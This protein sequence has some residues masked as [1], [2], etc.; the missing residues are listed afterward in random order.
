MI[1]TFDGLAATGKS[2]LANRLAKELCYE[3]LIQEYFLVRWDCF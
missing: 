3:Y 2:T 1:I